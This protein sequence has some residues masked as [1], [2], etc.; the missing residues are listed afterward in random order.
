MILPQKANLRAHE[1]PLRTEAF[2][3]STTVSLDL[4]ARQLL[5]DPKHLQDGRIVVAIGALRS[6][7][8]S[9]VGTWNLIHLHSVIHLVLLQ[10]TC[11]IVERAD[12]GCG[13]LCHQSTMV[14]R[15]LV[16]CGLGME[17][18]ILLSPL[19]VR[20]GPVQ[21]RRLAWTLFGALLSL[22][23]NL[24]ASLLKLSLSQSQ[25]IGCPHQMIEVL[26]ILVITESIQVYIGS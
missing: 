5:V 11:I 10:V 26:S 3:I 6:I 12:V 4:L 19:E 20:V 25:V 18:Q 2:Q 8:N 15:I 9:E 13:L 24:L 16:G 1:L 23:H 21:E 17:A 14:F 22:A 7:V